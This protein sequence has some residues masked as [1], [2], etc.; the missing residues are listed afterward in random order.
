MNTENILLLTTIR[1]KREMFFSEYIYNILSGK[2]Q[3][4]QHLIQDTSRNFAFGS[5][6]VMPCLGLVRPDSIHINKDLL[7]DIWKETWFCTKGLFN[8]VKMSLNEWQVS[9]FNCCITQT[10]SGIKKK[11]MS[12][13]LSFRGH[14]LVCQVFLCILHRSY[15]CYLRR[16][17]CIH[18]RGLCGSLEYGWTATWG[19]MLMSHLRIF[20]FA[21]GQTPIYGYTSRQDNFP[22]PF[23]PGSWSTKILSSEAIWHLRKDTQITLYLLSYHKLTREYHVLATFPNFPIMCLPISQYLTML[24]VMFYSAWLIAF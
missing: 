17:I 19:I 24:N 10:N 13:G 9:T 16:R 3:I 8:N 15:H 6:V 4:T 20:M 7:V 12:C 14:S 5:H 21:R 11:I 18:A 1:T 22:T 2:T 23:R